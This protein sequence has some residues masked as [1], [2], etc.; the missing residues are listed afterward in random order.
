MKDVFDEADKNTLQVFHDSLRKEY[1]KSLF[2]I[3][4]E[5]GY[6]SDDDSDKRNSM[7]AYECMPSF[8]RQH[9][10]AKSILSTDTPV[11]L[12][13]DDFDR[14]QY[15]SSTDIVNIDVIDSLHVDDHNGGRC[16]NYTAIF[17]IVS[18]VA[19][20]IG[21]SILVFNAPS[22]I[23]SHYVMRTSKMTLSL[24]ENMIPVILELPTRGSF[25]ISTTLS[26]CLGLKSKMY[27][28]R[29]IKSYE[30]SF[31]AQSLQSYSHNRIIHRE[32]LLTF[33]LQTLPVT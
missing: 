32:I 24:Q 29:L 6:S 15:I 26:K 25:S 27:S 1:M 17:L 21:S 33:S 5:E 14:G 18:I 2:G 28:D 10:S 11:S 20:A 13:A 31:Y 30:A 9:Q 7:L 22:S 3:H 23:I 19:L 4:A 16:P 8:S 12:I